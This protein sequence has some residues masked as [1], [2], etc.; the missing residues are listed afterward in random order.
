MAKILDI[1][2]EFLH[3]IEQDNPYKLIGKG[4]TILSL[5]Y[6]DRHRE[7]EDLDFD[8]TLERSQYQNI[9]SY[10]ISILEQLKSR[11]LIKSY[12]KGKSGLAATNRY[13]MNIALET[14]KTFHTKIDVDFVETAKSPEK[15]GEL[16]YYPIE[17][18]FIGKL[19]T[20]IARKEFKD[21]VNCANF[22]A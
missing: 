9:E 18:L 8:T 12:I 16:L 19:I 3:E 1:L 7:S 20:F 14:Y 6:L 13:H 17:R 4:G 11:K 15:K 10:F 21:I 22:V 2:Q 5:F